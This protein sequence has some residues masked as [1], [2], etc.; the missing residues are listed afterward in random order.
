MSNNGQILRL[1]ATRL[2]FYHTLV[3]SLSNADLVAQFN[4]LTGRSLGLRDPKTPIDAMIDKATGYDKERMEADAL[5]MAAFA[6]FVKDCVWD[7]LTEQDRCDLDKAA[8][9]DSHRQ[10]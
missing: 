6:E 4:R 5:D 8:L 2:G 10:H 9:H 7:R 3:T 1:L